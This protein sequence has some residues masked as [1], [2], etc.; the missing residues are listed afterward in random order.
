MAS[1]KILDLL[2][3]KAEYLLNHVS[4][5]IDKSAITLPSPT[6]VEEVWI[7]SNRSNQVLKSLQALIGKL[8]YPTKTLTIIFPTVTTLRTAL[9]GV[10]LWRKAAFRSATA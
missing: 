3:D 1:K 8:T 10:L 2:G 9:L 5:T 7:N 6:H 4:K